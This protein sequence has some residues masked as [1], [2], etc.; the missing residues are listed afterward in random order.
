VK[1]INMTL[2]S[3]VALSLAANLVAPAH[4]Q[5]Q[6]QTRTVSAHDMSNHSDFSVLETPNS[7]S[8][9]P[10]PDFITLDDY[11]PAGQMP[12]AARSSTIGGDDP[13]ITREAFLRRYPQAGIQGYNRIA[14]LNSL[15]CDTAFGAMDAIMELDLDFEKSDLSFEKLTAVYELLPKKMKGA[16]MVMTVAQ[17]VQTGA[18]CLLSAGMYCIAAIASFIGSLFVNKANLKLQLAHIKL[19]LENIV[20][21]RLNIHSNRITLRLDAMWAQI[22]A[23]DCLK[24]F[25]EKAARFGGSFLNALPPLRRPSAVTVS[26]GADNARYDARQP[27]KPRRAPRND[28]P[29]WLRQ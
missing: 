24:Q 6:T 1:I 5:A 11:T 26:Y 2:N 21:T 14:R 12:R 7:G 9:S 16:T 22:A 3:A 15:L 28:M 23:P 25:P 27:E 19:S 29:E 4:A 20:V 13:H 17:A 18:L 8:A 10:T